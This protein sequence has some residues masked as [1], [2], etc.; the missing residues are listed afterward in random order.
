MQKK[1]DIS[2]LNNQSKIG[3]EE[4][5]VL[6]PKN[7]MA[8]RFGTIAQRRKNLENLAQEETMSKDEIVTWDKLMVCASRVSLED[9]FDN[10]LITEERMGI[11]D[12]TLPDYWKYVAKYVLSLYDE[13]AI[14]DRYK[15][16][17]KFKEEYDQ[18]TR[19]VD[20]NR[21]VNDLARIEKN[22][23]ELNKEKDSLEQ[24]INEEEEMKNPI[25]GPSEN[26]PPKKDWFDKNEDPAIKAVSYGIDAA[27]AI[28]Q[29]Y[30]MQTVP[31]SH[32][33][34]ELEQIKES[35][36]Y[37]KNGYIVAPVPKDDGIHINWPPIS[38]EH[39]Q[40]GIDNTIANGYKMVLKSQLDDQAITNE[41]V[42]QLTE[43]L[44]ELNVPK[45]EMGKNG[46]EYSLMGRVIQ[47]INMIQIDY[48]N[49]TS[50]IP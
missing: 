1:L 3:E 10:I 11:T 44:N 13:N 35:L 32:H 28:A 41:E 29:S 42:S 9:L 47:L 25:Y 19:I 50:F 38:I 27:D 21:A 48:Q 18:K 33:F 40:K 7:G 43:W 30:Y 23:K 8:D 49:I 26:N 37:L 4:D 22:L 15:R 36:R 31:D 12:R 2:R 6:S 34:S 20:F 24:E 39:M 14:G 16:L 17:E 5:N 46:P 45:K